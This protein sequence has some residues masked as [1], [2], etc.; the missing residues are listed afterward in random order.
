MG[1]VICFPSMWAAST[2][3]IPEVIPPLRQRHQIQW[4]RAVHDTRESVLLLN[5]VTAA[6]SHENWSLRLTGTWIDVYISWQIEKKKC[7]NQLTWFELRRELSH[8]IWCLILSY[9]VCPLRCSYL[10]DK[11]KNIKRSI[12]Q[13][14]FFFNAFHLFSPS[15][16]GDKTGKVWC[17]L[18]VSSWRRLKRHSQIVKTWKQLLSRLWKHFTAIVF[19]DLTRTMHLMFLLGK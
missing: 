9:S 15:L 5:R 19:L 7:M 16:K 1:T 18:C 4:G 11:G 14:I 10:R 13:R 8:L 3:I 17:H 12:F 6:T 2:L